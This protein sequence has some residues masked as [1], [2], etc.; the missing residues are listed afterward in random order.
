MR[1]KLDENFG[2]RTAGVF[3]QLGHDVETVRDQ[4]LQGCSDD[5]L[6]ALCSRERRCLVTLDLDFADVIRFR[7]HLSAGIAVVRVPRNPSPDL[8]SAM[9]GGLL[10]ALPAHPVEGSLWI[11]EPGR[12]RI[13]QGRDE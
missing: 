4:G 13:H 6:F 1:F 7:P 9:I 10:R 5:N 12:I 3:R 11:V 8:L 2:S